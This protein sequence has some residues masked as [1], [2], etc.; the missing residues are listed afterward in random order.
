MADYTPLLKRAVEALAEKTPEARAA[1]YAR[2]REALGHHL[3]TR[4]PP[5][6]D[7]AIKTEEAAFE[8]AVAKIERDHAP[9]FAG[10]EPLRGRDAPLDM[11]E[12]V[13]GRPFAPDDAAEAPVLEVSLPNRMERPRLPTAGEQE[14]SHRSRIYFVLGGV[15]LLCG[16]GAVALVNREPASHYK[17]AENVRAMAAED[18]SKQE[19][20]L[21]AAE[22]AAPEQN[23]P[24]R[25]E[26][27]ASRSEQEQ[28]VQIGSRAF[29]V[30]EGTG[31]APGQFEGSAAWRLMPDPAGKSGAKAIRID[32]AFDAAGLSADL[33]LAQ[34]TD[35]SLSASHTL[36]VAFSPRGSMPAVRDL[37]PIEW[38]ERE[39][40]AGVTFAGLV[41]P[42]ADNLFMVGLD[43]SDYA[44]T[45][46]I[47][48]L[49]NL[50]WMVFEIRLANGK[51]GAM[52]IEKGSTGDRAVADALAQ[53][54]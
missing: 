11:I 6:D 49:R 13:D 41:V 35:A 3:A 20:R 50:K 52:L 33:T 10:A 53:W 43:K 46:N 39:N 4:Q 14:K 37:S 24:P 7:I 25:V 8:E 22:T 18:Q 21:G 9:A 31:T 2:A 29:M 1:V 42:I 23:P 51:R 44:K 36:L 45:R 12:P 15:I 5:L 27:Q 30:L 17:A 16:M 54:K 40:Q 26:Q 34:N 32:V 47:E 28:S 38:R 48:L 19:G